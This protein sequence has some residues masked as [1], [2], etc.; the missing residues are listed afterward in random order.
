MTQ[1]LEEWES[2]QF[3]LHHD[4][5]WWR[6]NAFEDRTLEILIHHC[7]RAKSFSLEFFVKA[8]FL[9]ILRK[10]FSIINLFLLPKIAFYKTRFCQIWLN[11]YISYDGGTVLQRG[12]KEFWS[13]Q[14]ILS[15]IKF[16]FAMVIWS[17]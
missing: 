16:L 7:V 5:I 3:D 8:Y 12:K 9:F 15:I 4:Y 14:R 6:T 17:S 2:T 13:D 11:R 1:N 10:Y